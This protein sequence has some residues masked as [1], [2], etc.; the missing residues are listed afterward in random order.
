MK[1]YLYHF[2]AAALIATLSASF[3]L[4]QPPAQRPPGQ[5][6]EQR[7]QERPGAQPHAAQ[8]PEQIIENWK[9]EAHKAAQAML[10]SY[11]PPDEITQE[12]LIWHDNGPWVRTEVVNEEIPHNF[13]MPHKDMLY[14]SV[15]YDVPQEKVAELAEFTGSVLVD[16]VKGELTARCDKE[17][18]NFLSINLSHRIIEGE[19][20][21]QE[22]RQI[23]AE[24]MRE[25][26]HPELKNSLVF[27]PPQE[28][29]GDPGQEETIFAGPGERPEQQQ[30]RPKQ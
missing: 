19:I 24:A 23:Y 18:P 8:Q 28:P 17:E 26:Q 14:Q 21:A 20:N 5:Q 1:T 29:Q 25:D 4:A 6:A 7:Q 10:Q 2:G 11:G 9:E 16:R 22:A 13:P 3:A 27:T 12:R 15:Y 30:E